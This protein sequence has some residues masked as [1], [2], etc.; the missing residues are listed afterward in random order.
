MSTLQNL[1]IFLCCLSK[2]GRND[3]YAFLEV[4]FDDKSGVTNNRGLKRD[5]EEDNDVGLSLDADESPGTNDLKPNDV[6]SSNNL[7]Y[8]IEDTSLSASKEN[9]HD[10][11]NSDEASLKRAYDD[12]LAARGLLSVSRSNEKLTDLALPAKMQRTLSQEFIKQAQASGSSSVS[13][14]F[15]N[16]FQ[17]SPSS[18]QLSNTTNFKTQ[19]QQ[20]PGQNAENQQTPSSKSAPLADPSMMNASVEVPATTK[21]ALCNSVNV[22]TQ[23]R[24]CGH[25]FHGR[26]LK[27]SLQTAL[28]P[29]CCPIDNIQMQSAVLAVPTSTDDS[30][31][32]QQWGS[33]M[34]RDYGTSSSALANDS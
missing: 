9:I 15:G 21:C 7:S 29:P 30:K 26:C 19:Q 1:C 16:P 18:Q 2:Q 5:R 13:F 23:L 6:Q 22:D 17:N 31:S 34:F 14:N 3:S 12:A 32:G 24:P 27:P 20:Y 33:N 8:N 25:M 28:G 4:F 10:S 11:Y